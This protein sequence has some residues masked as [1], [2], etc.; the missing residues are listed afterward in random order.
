MDPVRAG[1]SHVAHFLAELGE[2]RREDGWSNTDW[3]RHGYLS[4]D[5]LGG[6]TADAETGKKMDRNDEIG[7]NAQ[8]AAV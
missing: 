8:V 2:I 6:L 3:Q 4:P 5:R 1:R 7:V